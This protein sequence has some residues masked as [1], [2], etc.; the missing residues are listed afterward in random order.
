MFNRDLVNTRRAKAKIL[1]AN[2]IFQLGESILLDS[3]F[4]FEKPC[5]NLMLYG[6]RSG[7]PYRFIDKLKSI[8]NSISILDENA[9]ISANI[10]KIDLF[11]SFFDLNWQNEPK[12]FLMASNELLKPNAYIAGCCIGERSL[13]KLKRKL[14]ELEDKLHINHVARVSPMFSAMNISSLL[15]DAGYTNIIVALET[16][17]IE[18]DNIGHLLKDLADSGECNGFVKHMDMPRSLYKELM[19]SHDTHHEDFDI[20]VFFAKKRV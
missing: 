1:H 12:Y 14:I 17:S 19:S 8:N 15:Q 10:S 20:I 11:L 16:L 13:Y 4:L 7:F 9:N 5:N 2:Y 6:D 3:D 18:Y